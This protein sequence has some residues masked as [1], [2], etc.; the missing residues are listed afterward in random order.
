MLRGLRDP[1][2]AARLSY[3]ALNPLSYE[4]FREGDGRR[5]PDAP[6]SDVPVDAADPLVLSKRFPTW[7]FRRK[8]G[9]GRLYRE[10]EALAADLARRAPGARVLVFPCAPLQ[11]IEIV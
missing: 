9:K 10:W 7:G 5:S 4:A 6:I 8:F 1:L 2:L 3:F 11:L